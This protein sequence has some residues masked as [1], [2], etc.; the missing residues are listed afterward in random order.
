[1][2]LVLPSVTGI[3]SS[4][5]ASVARGVSL[6]QLS[7]AIATG[8]CTYAASGITVVTVDVGLFG[9]GVGVG[10][11]VI[12]PPPIPQMVASFAGSA[13]VGIFSA[14]IATAIATGISQALMTATVI[15]VHPT[16]GTG[17]GKANFIPNPGASSSAFVGAFASSGLVG[18][19]SA[20]MA[21]A[22]SVGLDSALPS[23]SSVIVI[24]GASTSVPSSGAG[25]GRVT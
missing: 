18:V 23:A 1:M 2:P 6:A 21:V 25:T 9:A 20:A 10:P 13:M 12:L 17:T 19:M 4:N 11:G 16:V 24:S 7:T 22:I 5:L 14:P 3:I 15:T 8:L